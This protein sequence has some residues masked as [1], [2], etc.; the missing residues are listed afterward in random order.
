MDRLA[1]PKGLA[2]GIVVIGLLISGSILLG[3]YA[4]VKQQRTDREVQRIAQRVFLI[5]QPTA[6]QKKKGVQRA[7]KELS[8]AAGA[9]IL[10]ALLKSATPEQRREL[11]RIVR[12]GDRATNPGSGQPGP[13]AESGPSPNV[14]SATVPSV[15]TPAVP[16]APSV[17]TPT[18]TTPPIVLPPL[19]CPPVPLKCP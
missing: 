9:Q 18:V 11:R 3:A 12:G 14:P 5:E 10:N 6:A 1:T 13:G 16:P 19:P 17:T 4:L 2:V 7:V 15:T 8:G